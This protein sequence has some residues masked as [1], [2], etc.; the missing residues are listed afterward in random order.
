MKLV[1]PFLSVSKRSRN[2]RWEQAAN[3][4]LLIPV[5]FFFFP[6]L[7]LYPETWGH[8]RAIDPQYNSFATPNK[9]AAFQK[10]SAFQLKEKIL[11]ISRGFFEGV[12]VWFLVCLFVGFLLFLFACGVVWWWWFLLFVWVFCCFVV[13]V[14]MWLSRWSTGNSW[15]A[16]FSEHFLGM[17]SV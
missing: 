6:Y 14:V 2:T 4:W 8:C 13:V 5:C 10:N 1:G 7:N 11:Q 9:N 12:F 16:I 15:I 3:I 17:A